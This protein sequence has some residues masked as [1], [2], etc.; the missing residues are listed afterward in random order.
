MSLNINHTIVDTFSLVSNGRH[1][2]LIKLLIN[3]FPLLK[4]R[5]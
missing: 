2:K 5:F 3:P 1:E 4:S